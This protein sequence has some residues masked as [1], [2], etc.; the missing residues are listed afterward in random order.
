LRK[1]DD[2][3]RL[4][5]GTQ[6]ERGALLQCIE[7]T[8]VFKGVAVVGEKETHTGRIYRRRDLTFIRGV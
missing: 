1:E 8:E 6:L 5:K 2:L 3:A 7:V 4:W